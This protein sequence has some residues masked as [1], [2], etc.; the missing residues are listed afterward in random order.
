MELKPIGVVRSEVEERG[1]RDWRGVDSEIV[2]TPALAEALDGLE[3]FSHIVVLFWMHRAP[4]GARS[5]T[6]VHPQMRQDLPEL[7]VFATRSPHRPNPL[8]LAVVEL[9][10]RRGQVLKVRGLDAIDGTP[11]LDLKPYLPSDLVPQARMPEWVWRAQEPFP[12]NG[13]R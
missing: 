5:V 8:G 12:E 9:V 3:E 6:R 13:A 10:E 7:G 2:V 11:V 4:P 1:R